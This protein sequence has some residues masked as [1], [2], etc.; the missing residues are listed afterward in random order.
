MGQVSA[1]SSDG[2]AGSAELGARGEGQGLGMGGPAA[3]PL[4]SSQEPACPR[5][6]KLWLE[7]P[8]AGSKSCRWRGWE[9]RCQPSACFRT[10]GTPTWE[11][12]PEAEIPRDV[13][14]SLGNPEPP[15]PCWVWEPHSALLP[16]AV[17]S[18]QSGQRQQ[19]CV[20][21]LG[22]ALRTTGR[23]RLLAMEARGFLCL[24]LGK[25]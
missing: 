14:W 25:Q 10:S 12:A 9:T 21:T 6:C 4:L 13:G 15:P 23:R 1:A 5:V 24:P 18:H 3:P 20:A 11:G 8:S 19:G 17:G 22:R 7:L 16:S 2:A